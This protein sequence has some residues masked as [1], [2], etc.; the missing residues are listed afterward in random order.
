MGGAVAPA[1]SRSAVVSVAG[2]AVAA[3]GPEGAPSG[4]RFAA[5]VPLAVERARLALR[6]EGARA[7][8][9]RQPGR[10]VDFDLEGARRPRLVGAG[11]G[12]HLQRQESGDNDQ[13]PEYPH[14]L[15]FYRTLPMPVSGSF[16]LTFEARRRKQEGGASAEAPPL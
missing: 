2:G 6:R 1:F 4:G 10:E 5:D 11:D 8:G 3:F 9:G 14:D 16:R 12:R 7:R 15:E 13:A